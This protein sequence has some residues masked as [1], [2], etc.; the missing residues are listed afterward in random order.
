VFT[1]ATNAITGYDVNAAFLISGLGSDV[2]AG[3]NSGRHLKHDFVV[4]KLV[5]QPLVRKN[6]EFQGSFVMPAE[7]KKTEGR[8]ALAVWVARRGR[9]EPVQAAGGWL[10]PSEMT[11]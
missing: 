8:L 2:K 6:D 9:P 11:K 1:P 4:I 7:Q 3:E 5:R 10:V